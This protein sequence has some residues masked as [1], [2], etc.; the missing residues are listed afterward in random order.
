MA[1]D[2]VD[3]RAELGWRLDSDYA[4]LCPAEWMQVDGVTQR[5]ALRRH[6][7]SNRPA[8]WMAVLPFALRR[9]S[10]AFA[11]RRARPA[12]RAPAPEFRTDPGA[13]TARRQTGH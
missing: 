4:S 8:E 10:S 11:P 7:A 12:L 6:V 2:D 13:C 1:V 3:P 5:A 9:P